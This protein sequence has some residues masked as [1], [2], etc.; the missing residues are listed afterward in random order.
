[1]IVLAFVLGVILTT[2][3]IGFYLNHLLKD[4]MF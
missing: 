1:M 2:I 4:K 3:V